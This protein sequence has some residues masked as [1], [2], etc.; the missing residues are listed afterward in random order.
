M[1]GS[2]KKLA[3]VVGI[4]I[5]GS[6][7][8]A[9]TNYYITKQQN[10]YSQMAVPQEAAKTAAF[11]EGISIINETGAAVAAFESNSRTGE[12]ADGENAAFKA[13]GLE[14]SPNQE[15]G[16]AFKG[17]DPSVKTAAEAGISPQSAIPD[18]SAI[19]QQ[20]PLPEGDTGDAGFIAPIAAME[21]DDFSNGPAA[22]EN[23]AAVNEKESIYSQSKKRLDDLDIQIQKMRDAQVDST[24]YSIKA[25]ADTELKLWDREL[26][27]IY[28]QIMDQLE[29]EGQME[30][31]RDQREWMNQRDIQAEEASPRNKSGSVESAGYTASLA[32]STRQR[33]YD[34]LEIYEA[35]LK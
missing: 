35:Y 31:A 21:A 22:E 17:S 15:E 18:E 1:A 4:I 28:I 16:A 23:L 27:N 10:N 20:E 26:S 3:L 19:S 33:A 24:A 25:L 12:M 29:K 7:I 34:L 8:T 32:A 14:D 11:A 2:S 13:K 6:L 5:A 30:L 9:Y